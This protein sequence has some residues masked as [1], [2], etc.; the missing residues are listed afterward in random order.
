MKFN[1]FILLIQEAEK[2]EIKHIV[3]TYREFDILCGNTRFF[4]SLLEK[5]NP[6]SIEYLIFGRKIVFD[7]DL[8]YQRILTK[9]RIKL[10]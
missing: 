9:P 8:E 5:I 6:R 3:L 4:H 1:K 2:R 10:T 7:E